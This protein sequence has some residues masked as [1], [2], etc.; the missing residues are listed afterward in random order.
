MHPT[1]LFLPLLV[2]YVQAICTGLLYW[3]PLNNACV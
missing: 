3:N 2:H 1:L